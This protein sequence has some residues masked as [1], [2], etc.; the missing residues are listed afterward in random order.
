[1][2]SDLAQL[3]YRAECLRTKRIYNVIAPKEALELAEIEQSLSA[4]SRVRRF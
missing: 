1:M 3:Q 4:N 2:H